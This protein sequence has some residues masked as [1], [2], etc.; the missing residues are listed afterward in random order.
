VEKGVDMLL[1]TRLAQGTGMRLFNNYRPRDAGRPL[2]DRLLYQ[3][4]MVRAFRSELR[5]FRPDLVHVKTSSGINFYQN[6]LYVQAARLAR[7]PVLLQLHCGKFEAFYRG[8]APHLKAWIRYTLT[9][10]RRV[11]VLSLH[12]KE[13]LSALA[14]GTRLV[15]I[16]NGLEPEELE[17]LAAPN[18][19]RRSQV[20]FLGTGEA[21]LNREK[22]LEDLLAVLPRLAADYPSVTWVLAGLETQD[23]AEGWWRGRGLPRP[24]RDRVLCRGVVSGEERVRL[25]RDSTLLVL[26]S[27]FENMPNLV[28]EAMAAG[29][30]VVATRVGALPEMLAEGEG[31][32]LFPPGDQTALEAALRRAL[33]EGDG[34]ARRGRRNRETVERHHTLA[35][36]ERGLEE[37]YREIARPRRTGANPAGEVATARSGESRAGAP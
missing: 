25:L 16:P 31:G 9:R 22:G 24:A 20:L 10:A 21:W 33:D 2:R 6:S 36:V 1:R 15:V 35:V 23:E 14:P 11:A 12:W 29:L 8:S 37:V 18:E 27:Y 4:G 32:F 7:L 13:R 34:L 17:S 3:A 28:L 19:G 26:P 5:S 30:A